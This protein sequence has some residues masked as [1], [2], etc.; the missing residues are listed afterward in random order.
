MTEQ[1]KASMSADVRPWPHFMT[2]RIAAQYAHTSPWTIRR[3][4]A[5]SGRRGRAF[6]YTIEAIDRW[7]R[8]APMEARVEEPA[9]RRRTPATSPATSIDKIHALAKPRPR[10]AVDDVAE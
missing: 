10:V 5:P 3:N 7:M 2:A 1:L 4:V 9:R 6:V 8:G